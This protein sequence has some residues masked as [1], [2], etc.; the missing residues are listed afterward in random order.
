[1][2][3]VLHLMLRGQP[4]LSILTTDFLPPIGIAGSLELK[5]L[6]SMAYLRINCRK[7]LGS[8]DR[9]PINEMKKEAFPLLKSLFTFTGIKPGPLFQKHRS[10]WDRISDSDNALVPEDRSG[11]CC[12]AMGLPEK[13]DC[14]AFCR[15]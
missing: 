13:V 15:V 14:R 1:M 10:A 3:L 6:T 12:L 9:I 2:S 8:Q 7:A 11:R 4:D 5:W